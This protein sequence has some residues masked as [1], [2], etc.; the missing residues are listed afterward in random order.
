[1]RVHTYSAGVPGAVTHPDIAPETKLTE[2]LAVNV[3]ERVYR[4]GHG[5]EIDIKLTVEELFGVD[6]GH[7]LVHHCREIT[8]IVA[9]VGTD[10][11]IEVHPSTHVKKVREKA[12]AAFGL[13]QAAS[14]DLVLRLPGSGNELPPTSPIGAFS[15]Q[16]SCALTL[17]L[18]HLVRPQG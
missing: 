18:V 5:V 10:Q 14:A 1:M 3:D 6:P 9:Y 15:A 13:D 7:V 8:V 2:L 4:V 16:G 17:D 12:I 11:R